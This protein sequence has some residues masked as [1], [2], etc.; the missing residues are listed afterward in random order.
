MPEVAPNPDLRKRLEEKSTAELQAELVKIDSERATTIDTDNRRRLIR[1][2]EIRQALGRVPPSPP[3]LKPTHQVLSL[4]LKTDRDDLR[5]RINER[6]GAAL[7]KGLIDETRSLLE[8]G[9]T[10]DRLNEI[11]LEYRLVLEHLDGLYDE[12]TLL[13]KIGNTPNDN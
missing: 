10:R 6:A 9:L 8:S 13:K 4:G 11:G 5:R 3:S 7:K 12:T 2:I 1:A